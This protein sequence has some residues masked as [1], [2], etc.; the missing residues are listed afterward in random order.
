LFD[1]VANT[2]AAQKVHNL[3]VTKQ[4]HL[5]NTYISNLHDIRTSI[6][7]Q[8]KKEIRQEKKLEQL[9]EEQLLLSHKKS[10]SRTKRYNQKAR[11]RLIHNGTKNAVLQSDQLEK[12]LQHLVKE[13]KDQVSTIVSADDNMAINIDSDKATV[14]LDDSRLQLHIPLE[15]PINPN[16]EMVIQPQVLHNGRRRKRPKMIIV[17]KTQR[18]PPSRLVNEEHARNREH[19]L[20]HENLEGYDYLVQEYFLDPDS[21]TLYM[22]INTYLDNEIYKATVCPIDCE[23]QNITILQSPEFKSLNILGE[24]GVIDLV[25][26]F[27]NI[28]TANGNWPTT[29][30]AWLEVQSNDESWLKILT[31]LDQHNTCIIIKRA[32]NYIDYV[33]REILDDGNLG[34]LIRYISVPKQ[35]SHSHLM[36][37]YK[38]EFRQMIVPD[39]LIM[40][41]MEITHRALGH[42]GFHRMW[43]TIRKSYY[44]KSMQHDVRLYCSNCHY[45]RF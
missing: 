30:N 36:I 1:N 4:W 2:I 33:T 19:E 7:L 21:D 32:E 23:L 16:N 17:D 26:K 34:P 18:R 8:R 28:V 37:S 25:N 3:Q 14:S 38:E 15:S 39:T 24:H 31:K 10:Q 29:N 35:L 22:V 5:H 11:R 6:R 20:V 40:L 27:Y 12:N 41:C 45:C 44:W 13:F 9:R 42:P 43:N